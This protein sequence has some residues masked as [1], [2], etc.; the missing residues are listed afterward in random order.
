MALTA[1]LTSSG[2]ASAGAVHHRHHAAAAHKAMRKARAL[3]RAHFAVLRQH[4]SARDVMRSRSHSRQARAKVAA[5]DSRLVFDGG[6]DYR[7]YL[8]LDAPRVCLSAVNETHGSS[9]GGCAP[10]AD[11]VAGRRVLMLGDFKPDS[12]HVAVAAL[13]GAHDAKATATD[14]TETPLPITNNVIVDTLT[15]LTTIS[16]TD[17]AGNVLTTRFGPSPLTR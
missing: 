7:L 2:V 8:I 13:D 16:F 14:G 5:I 3:A 4:K 10:I 15:Q 9:G 11:V 12:V 17:A 6:P 1:V